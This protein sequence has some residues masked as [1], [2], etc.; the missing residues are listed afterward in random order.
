MF[1][2]DGRGRVVEISR[3]WTA[4]VVAG[5]APGFGDGPGDV[6]RFR[7]PAGVAIAERGRLIVSDSGNRLVRSVSALSQLQWQLPASPLIAPQFDEHD[8]ATHGLLWPVT[9]MEG[10]HEIAGTMGEA[11]GEG[12]DRLHAGI[13]VRA[14]QGT[15]VYAVRDASVDTPIA[16]ADFGSLNERVS[17][18]P[19]EYVHIRV[20]RLDG[21]RVLDPA[22]FVPTYGDKGQLT[23]IR[24]KRGAR[25]RTGELVGS[26]NNFNHVHL[27]IGWPGEEYNPLRF[28]LVQFVDT[29]APVISRGGVRLF[30]DQSQLLTARQDGRLL[31]SG[32]LQIV[33]DAWDQVDGNRPGRRLGL[34]ELGYQVI[35]P[36][37][38][39]VDAFGKRRDTIRFDRL[40]D[41][42][43]PRLVYAPGSG[44]P[45]YGGRTTRFLYVASNRFRQGIAASDVWDAG[46][47]PPGDYV[48]RV[49]AADISGNE[50]MVNRDV[51]IRVLP[52]A[53]HVLQPVRLR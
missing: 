10:P 9:P 31:V 51:N 2:T 28:R 45:F 6:A 13:D 22:R 30:D 27:N 14:E 3:E 4:R 1:V 17:I 20:G 11:R 25:F 8:L 42:E 40:N 7:R 29:V 33:V 24:V 43:A 44:I 48:L 49:R 53:T 32:L 46:L 50:A 34:Y 41:S 26:V 12:A 37:G 47:L 52:S 15:P 23:R 16:I 36:D 18:G 39:P 19:V 38:T 5:S 35:N 21:R